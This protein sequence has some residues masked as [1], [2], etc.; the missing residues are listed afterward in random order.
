MPSFGL[1]PL[2]R[3]RDGAFLG[4]SDLNA[5]GQVQAYI[6]AS[7]ARAN[8]PFE[9][10]VRDDERYIIH[11][12]QFLHWKASVAVPG[13]H[14]YVNDTQVATASATSGYVDLSPLG[15]ALKEP[16]PRVRST[17]LAPHNMVPPPPGLLPGVRRK[18]GSVATAAKL[19][20]LAGLHHARIR[21]ARGRTY[22]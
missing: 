19:C 12:S 22:P 11:N 5:I 16:A 2:P 18:R 9:W 10:M 20:R 6:A 21:R 3:F 4:A 13:A 7:S 8:M 15:L 1:P 17:R 14:L